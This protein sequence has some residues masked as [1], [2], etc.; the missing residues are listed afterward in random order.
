[1]K[2]LVDWLATFITPPLKEKRLPPVV[3]NGETIEDALRN[4]AIELA[5]EDL[6]WRES[7]GH[8]RSPE[9]DRVNIIVGVPLGSPYCKSAL[10]V[11]VIDR[12]CQTY[13][14]V[15]PVPRNGSSQSM[16]WESP[17]EFLKP[18]GVTPKKADIGILTKRNAPAYGHI[19]L[20]TEV[21][22]E[23]K[24]KTI[25]YNTN[26][27]GARDGDGCHRLERSVNGSPSKKFSYYCDWVAWVLKAN[28]INS[29]LKIDGE[30]KPIT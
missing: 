9:I 27:A 4:T 23:M 30:V 13:G 3:I 28:N 20:V 19:Y 1:M 14:L 22:N 2:M 15:N 29:N 21:I 24:H 16:L 17:R 26:L 10:W 25:E 6:G 11:R 5:E 7:K 18:A 8:N 12:A